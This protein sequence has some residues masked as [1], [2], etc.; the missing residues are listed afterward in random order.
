MKPMT[1]SR[2]FLDTLG[3]WKRGWGEDQTLRVKLA[4]RLLAEAAQLPAEFRTVGDRICYRKRFLVKSDI[5]PL[6]Q[7]KLYDGVTSWTLDQS[8]AEIFKGYEREDAITAT[9]FEHRPAP[10][11]V[12]LN[13]AALWESQE[14]NNA[15]AAYRADNGAE[16]EA[17]AVIGAR[18]SEV[19]L[20][21]QLQ[22]GEIIAFTGR[23]SSFDDLCAMAGI[24]LQDQDAAW[25]LLIDLGKQPETPRYVKP[26][27]VKAILQKIEDL[28][29]AR[30]VI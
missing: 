29:R 15:V 16:A 12:V 30:G 23:S 1:F 11:E 25:R 6:L 21:A 24:R 26:D 17:Y 9:I 13:I 7:G 18:Q 4:H 19:V 3:E 2:Q 10:A 20:D 27:R 5:V 8:F 14:F 28:A 22:Y